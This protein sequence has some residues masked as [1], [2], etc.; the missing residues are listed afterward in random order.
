MLCNDCIYND[1]RKSH[2][3]L[4]LHRVTVP[5]HNV[6]NEPRYILKWDIVY[7]PVGVSGYS[8]R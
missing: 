7:L 3:M 2:A 8:I 5:Y 4:Y 6:F 1:V